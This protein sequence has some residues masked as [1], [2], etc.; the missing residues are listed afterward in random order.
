MMDIP[1]SGLVVGGGS[2]GSSKEATL[3]TSSSNPIQLVPLNDDDLGDGKDKITPNDHSNISESTSLLSF[4]TAQMDSYHS[5]LN[6]RNDPS[7]TIEKVGDQDDVNELQSLFY[8]VAAQDETSS[9]N[10]IDVDD[11]ETRRLTTKRKPKCP[12]P[13][14]QRYYRF[15]TH[16]CLT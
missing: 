11:E 10:N 14:V 15:T 4:Q 7:M 5:T 8:H 9:S 12:N 16:D 6:L 13:T 2:T 1:D 3:T